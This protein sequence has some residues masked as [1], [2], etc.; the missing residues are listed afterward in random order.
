VQEHLAKIDGLVS[1]RTHLAMRRYNPEE[2]S[3]A[4]DLG[5]D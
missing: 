1:T 4:F 3:A 2:I 5:V